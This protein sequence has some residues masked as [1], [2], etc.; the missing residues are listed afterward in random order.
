MIAY[1]DTS[2]FVKIYITEQDSA[3]LRV[4]VEEI[5]QIIGTSM[6]TRPEFSAAIARGVHTG[7]IWKNVGTATRDRFPEEW[8]D[9]QLLILS[10]EII[11][12]ADELAWNHQLGGFDAIHLA[13]ALYWQNSLDTVVTF[14][15]FDKP[16]WQKTQEVSLAVWPEALK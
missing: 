15:T 10:D 2:T 6:V 8:N 12:M 14:V 11:E 4:R 5:L 13:S 3:L 7:M 1:L 9:L 16:L